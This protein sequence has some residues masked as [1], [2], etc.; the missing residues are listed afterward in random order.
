M[1]QYKITSNLA[2]SDNGFMFLP[3]TGES[4]TLNPIGKEIVENL[5]SAKTLEEISHTLAEEYDADEQII[6]RDLN[7]FLQQLKNF[8]LIE[9]LAK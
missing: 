6:E 3:S 4:F 9:E 8:N 7:D 1:E 2:I 5:K